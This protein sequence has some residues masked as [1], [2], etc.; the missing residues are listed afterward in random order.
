MARPPFTFERNTLGSNGS[1]ALRFIAGPP[2]A[3][4]H[5]KNARHI[6]AS[7]QE[8]RIKNACCS[9]PR[10]LRPPTVHARYVGSPPR[11]VAVTGFSAP[12]VG[13]HGRVFDAIVLGKPGRDP[14]GTR[15]ATLEA[16]LFESGR[17]VLIAPPTPQP[18]T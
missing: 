2:F 6:T 5:L 4:V 7:L 11:D 1:F 16:G 3:G 10:W 9:A 17:P 14:K 12:F 15:M 18:Q 8:P 13:S